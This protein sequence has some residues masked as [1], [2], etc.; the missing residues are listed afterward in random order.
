MSESFVHKMFL[1]MIPDNFGNMT[2]SKICFEVI[3][4]YLGDHIE[5]EHSAA[6][7]FYFESFSI[8]L[9]KI[10]CICGALIMAVIVCNWQ[11]H[12]ATYI[13][14]CVCVFISKYAKISRLQQQS[15]YYRNFRLTDHGENGDTVLFSRIPEYAYVRHTGW[16]SLSVSFIPLYGHLDR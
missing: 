13:W 5:P 8:W 14:F 6:M 4:N 16:I 12:R 7:F 3:R 10:S 1:F 2:L 15:V 11:W 9:K